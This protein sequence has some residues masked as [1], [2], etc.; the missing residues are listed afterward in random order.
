MLLDDRLADRQ[1]HSHAVGLG[2]YERL[3]QTVSNLGVETWSG[4]LEQQEYVAG[5]IET[6]FNVQCFGPMIGTGHGLDRVHDHIEDDL[7]QL[8]GIRH[9]P[10][11]WSVHQFGFER[12]AVESDRSLA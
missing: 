3:E 11:A 10:R 2:R 1:P 12:D 9:H 6:R 8:N 5:L 7:L 4:I